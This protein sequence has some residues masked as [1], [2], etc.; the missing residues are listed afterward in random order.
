[1][2]FTFLFI[3]PPT[4]EIYTLSL[5]DALPIWIDW[6]R[7]FGSRHL[8]KFR[9]FPLGNLPFACQGNVGEFGWWNRG[10]LGNLWLCD[11]WLDWCSRNFGNHRTRIRVGQLRKVFEVD[12]GFSRFH[13]K[14]RRSAELPVPSITRN[15]AVGSLS[16]D[17]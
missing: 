4:S 16:V 5:H 12:S 6:R 1:T 8:R 15:Q 2:S 14:F 17:L 11:Y 10:P 3:A 7:R 13:K 9:N